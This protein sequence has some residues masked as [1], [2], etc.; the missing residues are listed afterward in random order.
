MAEILYIASSRMPTE[1]GYGYQI[2]KMCEAFGVLGNKVTLIY[3]KR[4]NPISQNIFDYYKVK[5]FQ[6]KEISAPDFIS[7]S[8]VF[9][10]IFFWLT[11]IFYLFKLNNIPVEKGTIIYTRTA[12][13]AWIFSRK[14]YKT[15]F[16][17]HSF[18]KS[19]LFIYK[20]FLSGVFLFVALTNALK[21]K[22]IQAGIEERKIIVSPDAVDLSVFSIEISKEQAR[23]KFN[24][25]HEKKILGYFGN[26]KTMGEDKGISLILKA[27]KNMPEEVVFLAVGG[28]PEDISFYERMI[29]PS[30]KPRVILK[31]RA[32]HSDLAVYQKACDILLMPFPDTT[33]YRLYMSPL[34]MFEYMASWRPI[35]ASDLPSVRE[36]LNEENSCLVK[37]DDL[38][39][40][41]RGISNIIKNS[42]YA[43][44]ISTKA[45]KDV[46]NHTWEKRAG[47]IAE[48]IIEN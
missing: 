24:I 5:E 30:L 48:K 28:K 25:P 17:I 39:E 20:K 21:E 33:H 42:K 9:G 2:V 37:P 22:L 8:H 41:S 40:L 38:E 6:V 23:K 35:I 19:K 10:K 16:E 29:E 11:S 47:K 43:E 36:V 44:K 4:K 3:P 18:P 26:F 14:G 1:K 12:E 34:K 27:L 45:L 7:T 31:E 46:K 32:T 13:I 15:I